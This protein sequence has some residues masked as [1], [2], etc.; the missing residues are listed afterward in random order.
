MSAKK[1]FLI[2]GLALAGFAGVY[3]LNINTGFFNSFFYNEWNPMGPGFY[4]GHM[5]TG[6]IM[7]FIFWLV[8]I[9]FL[10]S[11]LG[12]KKS[13]LAHTTD[14]AVEILKKKYVNGDIG[15]VEFAD[16]MKHLN[17]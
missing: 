3:F 8:L 6:G 16:K 1:I 2:I 12:G 14:S 10:I 5:M 7:H 11:A 15:K 13:S 9:F 4:Y 17:G